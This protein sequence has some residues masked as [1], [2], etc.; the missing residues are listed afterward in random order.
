LTVA[1][2]A[3]STPDG[4]VVFMDGTRQLATKTLDGSGTASYSAPLRPGMH[5]IHA[6]YMGNSNFS[7][8]SS[9]TQVVNVSPRPKPR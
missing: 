5:S 7:G 4:S 9:S 6:V 1:V 3:T 2:S 8:S